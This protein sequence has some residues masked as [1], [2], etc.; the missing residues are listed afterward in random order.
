MGIIESEGNRSAEQQH[1]KQWEL[2]ERAAKASRRSSVL[3][4]PHLFRMDTSTQNQQG[5]PRLFL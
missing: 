1:I 3:F 4:P 5:V 2:T